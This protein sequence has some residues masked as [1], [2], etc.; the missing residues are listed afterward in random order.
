MAGEY[1]H[2]KRGSCFV[3]VHGDVPPRD[4]EFH[5]GFDQI[6]AAGALG[7]V[8][9]F[10]YAAGSGGPNATQR[11]RFGVLAKMDA[12]AVLVTDSRVIRG[13]L[14]A[15]AWVLP[16]TIRGFPT[17]RAADALHALECSELQR[18]HF[19]EMIDSLSLAGGY[20]RLSFTSES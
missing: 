3:I 17:H 8:R 2:T 10:V 7:E 18:Q 20:P 1:L 6:E 16:A 5:R 15:V 9:V 19:V 14:T 4:E 11:Q 12:R 13:I